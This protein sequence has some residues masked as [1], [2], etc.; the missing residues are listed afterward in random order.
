MASRHQKQPPARTAVSVRWVVMVPFPFG[1]GAGAASAAVI[2]SA[3]RMGTKRSARVDLGRNTRAL[4]F[5]AGGY[6]SFKREKE[7]RRF[8]H[9]CPDPANLQELDVGE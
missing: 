1:A 8:Q 9:P 4:L 6:P 7:V 2:D 5:L 3:R